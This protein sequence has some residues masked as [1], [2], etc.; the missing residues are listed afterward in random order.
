MNMSASA[1]PMDKT[2]TGRIALLITLGSESVFFLTLLV[3]YVALRD[4]VS[5]NVPHTI[6]RLSIPIVNTCVLFISTIMAY[7]A[8]IA[9]RRDNRLA[10]RNYLLITILLGLAFVA[11]QIY[12]FSHA[13]LHIGDQS[14]GGV[15]FTLMGFHALHVLGGVVFL[16]LNFLRTSLGDF[17][18]LRHEAVELGVW[19]WYYVAAVWLVLF[20]ALYLV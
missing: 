11:G 6:I 19:F 9:I 10:L 4:E 2:S 13:G 7:Q 20:A 16:I 3:A 17:N 18:A 14:F 12:E 15:F 8:H 5:W 1:Q